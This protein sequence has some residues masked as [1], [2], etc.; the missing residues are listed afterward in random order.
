M[1]MM[2][3]PKDLLGKDGNSLGSLRDKVQEARERKTK[4]KEKDEA[5]KKKESEEPEGGAVFFWREAFI[6]TLVRPLEPKAFFARLMAKKAG[7]MEDE[8]GLGLKLVCGKRLWTI[9]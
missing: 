9:W 4:G 5:T 1:M 7:Q 8:I 6:K 2:L 3:R